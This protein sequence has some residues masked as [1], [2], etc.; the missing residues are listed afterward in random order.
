VS[1]LQP[2][3]TPESVSDEVAPTTTK[4]KRAKRSAS[5]DAASALN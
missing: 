2:A 3:A 5:G 1:T 4:V